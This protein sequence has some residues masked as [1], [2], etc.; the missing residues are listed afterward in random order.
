M[1]PRK[2]LKWGAWVS[3]E[4][5][6]FPQTSAREVMYALTLRNGWSLPESEYVQGRPMLDQF[7]DIKKAYPICWLASPKVMASSASRLFTHLQ[8]A[9]ASEPSS[10]N[11]QL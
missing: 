7:L 3:F 10:P 4:Q 11:D 6:R 8:P 5:K 1:E 9:E 2:K